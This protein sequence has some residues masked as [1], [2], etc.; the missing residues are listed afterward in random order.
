MGFPPAP[1]SSGRPTRENHDL[2]YVVIACTR[3]Y[4]Q[5]LEFC[6]EY[7]LLLTP[8]MPLTAW[9]ADDRPVQNQG[10]PTPSIFDRLPFTFP[11]YLTGQP[12]SSVRSGFAND[13]LLVAFQIVGRYRANTL[14]LQAAEACGNIAPWTSVWPDV[15]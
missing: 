6:E 1:E 15:S 10:K 5:A 9:S 12:A 11:F 7:N 8:Q 2:E 3:F 14:V 4:I 13:G